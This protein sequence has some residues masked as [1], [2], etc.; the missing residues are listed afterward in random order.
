MIPELAFLSAPQR[1]IKIDNTWEI[2]IKICKD[3]NC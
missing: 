3:V 2:N 1:S